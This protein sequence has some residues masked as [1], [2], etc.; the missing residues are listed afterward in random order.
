HRMLDRVRDLL[1]VRLAHDVKGIFWHSSPYQTKSYPAF[2]EAK[3]SD[4]NSSP[5]APPFPLETVP[6]TRPVA[7]PSPPHRPAHCVFPDAERVQEM[8]NRFQSVCDR[9]ELPSPHRVSPAPS[10]TSRFPRRR[11]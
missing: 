3:R 8:A 7:A 5:S 11:S 9:S 10:E 2:R 4:R 1:H 6:A